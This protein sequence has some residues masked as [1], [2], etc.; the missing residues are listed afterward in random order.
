MKQKRDENI[1]S[2]YENCND[3]N[4]KRKDSKESKVISCIKE[5]FTTNKTLTRDKFDEFLIFI[6]LKS[7]WSTEDEQNILWNS[8]IQNSPN[9]KYIDYESALRGILE[10]FTEDDDIKN[11]SID[12]ILMEENNINESIDK[13]LKS[14]NGS[15]K[16]LYDIEFINYIFFDK[17]NINITNNSIENI[18][19]EIKSKYKFITINEKDI[20][21]YLNLFNITVNKDIINYVNNSIDNILEQNKINNNNFYFLS[22][23]TNDNSRAISFSN[24]LQNKDIDFSFLNQNELFD[25]LLDLDKIIFDCMDSLIHFYNKKYLIDLTKKYIQNYLLSTKNNI[26]NS[27]K[28]IIENENKRKASESNFSESNE[29]NNNEINI[30]KNTKQKSKFVFK[31]ETHKKGKSNI[32]N[33]NIN[34]IINQNNNNNYNKNDNNNIQFVENENENEIYNYND[35][36]NDNDNENEDESDLRKSLSQPK[37][38]LNRNKSDTHEKLITFHFKKKLKKNISYC[39]LKKLEQLKESEPFN[40]INNNE[41]NNYKSRNNYFTEKKQAQT[42]RSSRSSFG[43]SFFTGSMDDNKNEIFP[44]N[45][46][47]ET[48]LLFE[49]TDNLEN[50]DE[51]NDLIN[52]G[53]PTLNPFDS[54]DNK[55]YSENDEEN[56]S[57]YVNENNNNNNNNKNNNDLDNLNINR[58]K[59]K[60]IKCQN[61][62]NFTFGSE[63]KTDNNKNEDITIPPKIKLSGDIDEYFSNYN[64][65]LINKIHSNKK[66]KLGHYDFKYIYKNNK[67]KKLFISNKDKMNIMEFLTDDIF[68]VSSNGLKKQKATLVISSLYFYF[69]KQNTQM[70][71]ISKANINSLETIS[72]SSRNC[73]L[74]HF[75]FQKGTDFIVETFRRMEILRFLK[76][77]IK[78]KKIKINVSHNFIIKKKNG[79]TET[80]NFKKLFSY[81]PNFENTYKIGIL[82][83]YQENFFSSRFHERLVVLCSIGLM[84]FEENEKIPKII[85]PIIGTTIKYIQVQGSEKLYCF[86]LKTINDEIYVF[87]SKIKKEIYDWMYEFFMAKIKYSLKLKDISPNIITQQKGKFH[88]QKAF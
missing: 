7:I 21:K 50:V 66:F 72:L 47:I 88:K 53:T 70:T 22:T 25:K 46:N 13:F 58:N 71:C 78:K 52:K 14:L 75:S 55:D 30:L 76:D 81:T 83:K 57:D 20:K 77:T 74:V 86:Q 42:M 24:N 40:F 60:S 12:N 4:F 35:N 45:N 17:D 19:S 23:H 68:I 63:P 32:L 26:Y 36:D 11:N 62:N 84:Y 48:R 18:F 2:K 82:F 44:I 10:L 64:N 51:D 43:N 28:Q 67:I 16:M 5:Y 39:D 9:K 65:T 38:K 59:E 8:I 37:R 79:E 85:I 41:E 29:E 31:R 56:F 69:L 49:S 34:K 80:I 61:P 73:N 87:G 3:F 15:H 1:L 54:M 27:L 6:D 33:I